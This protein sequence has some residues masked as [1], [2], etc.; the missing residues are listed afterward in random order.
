MKHL[1]ITLILALSA[2]VITLTYRSAHSAYNAMT[3]SDGYVKHFCS[4]STSKELTCFC[5][6][7]FA[8]T[9]PF[10]KD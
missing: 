10:D 8:R 2:I 6:N 7:E 4:Q 5:Y 9:C 1:K 3:A